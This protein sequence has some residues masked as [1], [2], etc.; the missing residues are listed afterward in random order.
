MAVAVPGLEQ[1]VLGLR[2]S[3]RIKLGRWDHHHHHHPQVSPSQPL[4]LSQAPLCTTLVQKSIVL[5]K[6]DYASVE[7]RSRE[8]KR[9]P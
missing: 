1:G 9:V 5:E 2:S 4:S 7:R 6:M 8:G 3:G